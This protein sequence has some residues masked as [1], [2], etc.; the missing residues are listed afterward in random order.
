MTDGKVLYLN[1][2]SCKNLDYQIL[3]FSHFFQKLEGEWG[4]CVDPDHSIH[5]PGHSAVPWCGVGDQT[6]Q[7]IDSNNDD[8]DDIITKGCKKFPLTDCDG[9]QPNSKRRSAGR[10]F[11][12]CK[13]LFSSRSLFPRD[14]RLL[15]ERR[16][17][18]FRLPTM[19]VESS[20][21]LR[22]LA[23]MCLGVVSTRWL[24]WGGKSFKSLSLLCFKMDKNKGNAFP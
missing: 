3:L 19:A 2:E 22:R 15:G 7:I 24:S 21:F 16:R 1:C 14:Q 9:V 11:H 5:Q 18:F 4:I 20:L 10:H 17:F 6:S 13:L 8:G 12:P 23:L